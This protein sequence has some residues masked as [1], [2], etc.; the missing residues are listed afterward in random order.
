MRGEG[1]WEENLCEGSFPIRD[2]TETLNG[3]P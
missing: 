3:L 1:D 2:F